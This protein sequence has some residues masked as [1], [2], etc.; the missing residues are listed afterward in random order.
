[1]AMSQFSYGTLESYRQRGEMLPVDG[2]FDAEGN[3][4]RDP[5]AIEQSQRPLPIGYWKGSG[6]S[7]VLEMI[8]VMTSLGKAT[9]QLST[10]PLLETGL[11]QVFLAM[12]PEALGPSE[13]LEQIA[14]EIVASVH[15]CK[16][17]EKGMKIRYPGEETLRVRAENKKLGLP[18]EPEVWAQILGM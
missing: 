2:G 17:V 13:K 9:H 7:M 12:N 5:A 14:D 10:D 4:T 6:L 16:L 11:S 8:A 18:V 3:L 1:M 15:H